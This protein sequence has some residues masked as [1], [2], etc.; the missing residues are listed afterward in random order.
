[1]SPEDI[2][3]THN[4][5]LIAEV[6]DAMQTLDE[7]VNRYLEKRLAEC[8]LSTHADL[9]LSRREREVFPLILDGLFNK[10]IAVRLGISERTVKFHVS[11]I[12]RKF[13]VASRLDLLSHKVTPGLIMQTREAGAEQ[14]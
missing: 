6:V 4:Q 3:R 8:K 1:M 10:E 12:L 9:Q 13:G 7:R 2:E 11:S 5:E 14:R